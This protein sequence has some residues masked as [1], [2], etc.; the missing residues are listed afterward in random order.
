LNS[1][2]DENMTQ[3]LLSPR[4]EFHNNATDLQQ[5]TNKKLTGKKRTN[6]QPIEYLETESRIGLSASGTQAHTNYPFNEKASQCAL[7]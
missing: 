3:R 1:N 4:E 2:F 6:N 7:S 5:L